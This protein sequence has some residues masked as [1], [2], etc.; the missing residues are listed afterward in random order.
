MVDYD[1]LLDDFKLFSAREELQKILM[2]FRSEQRPRRLQRA[3]DHGVIPFPGLGGS[4]SGGDCDFQGDAGVSVPHG[5]RQGSETREDSAEE[6]YESCAPATG[7]HSK[8]GTAKRQRLSGC[9][10]DAIP[11]DDENESGRPPS[12]WFT[13]LP[14]CAC[15]PFSRVL[16]PF[17]PLFALLL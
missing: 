9:H 7:A 5:K 8:R 12:D 16:L 1:R 10:P 11:S 6:L 13:L 14:L 3:F 2:V 15:H 4:I 17:S